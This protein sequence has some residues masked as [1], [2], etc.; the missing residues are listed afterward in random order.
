MAERTGSRKGKGRKNVNFDE[1][2]KKG[3]LE[4]VAKSDKPVAQILQELGISRSTY[5]NWLKRFEEEGEEGLKD[6]RDSEVR[7]GSEDLEAIS[8]LE[9]PESATR[10]SPY[11]DEAAPEPPSV[12]I[13][14]PKEK[15]TDRE[16]EP[17]HV[18]VPSERTPSPYAADSCPELPAPPLVIDRPAASY[19][20]V[21]EA[22]A[23]AGAVKTERVAVE[24]GESDEP[25]EVKPVPSGITETGAP[26]S[27]REP[28]ESEMES[29]IPGKAAVQ[30]DATVESIKEETIVS[31]QPQQP[32]SGQVPPGKIGKGSRTTPT[33]YF[34]IAI[35]IGITGIV[36]TLS[37]YNAA[38]YFFQQEDGKLALWKGRFAPF[39]TERVDGF[40]PLDT[41]LVDATPVLEKRFHGEWDALN[42]LF[43]LIL[44][45]A[46]SMLSGADEP[47]Y[48]AANAYLSLA[49]SIA[50]N[51]GEDSPQSLMMQ[52]HLVD[53]RIGQTEKRLGGLY[54]EKENIL[55]RLHA[56]GSSMTRTEV[57][58]E[59]S[60]VS[61]KR[62]ELARWM[63]SPVEDGSE[64]QVDRT[65]P[66]AAQG[67]RAKSGKPSGKMFQPAITP[68][69]EKETALSGKG[70]T[71]VSES[72]KE[73]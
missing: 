72:G 21:A 46:D 30:P 12:F 57:E 66:A 32:V 9:G 10:P 34:L 62:K 4:T 63:S 13:E 17:S 26:E 60:R 28:E 14:V 45:K 43:M 2:E 1:R 73:K 8:A 58:S 41:G 23:H 67:E 33:F 51:G 38:G 48:G 29:G 44:T 54:A 20:T 52:Y 53:K 69:L 71:G 49:E 24:P 65:G 7:R 59:L 40:K 35:V 16:I 50:A 5:Y 61:G 31:D 70:K 15:T 56:P 47:D 36:L 64:A 42:S 55:G 3:I 22:S 18:T 39:G 25:Q 37:M 6:K 27:L 68:A 19:A 11:A